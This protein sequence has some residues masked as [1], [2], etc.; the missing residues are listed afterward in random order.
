MAEL[1]ELPKGELVPLEAGKW[2]DVRRTENAVPDHQPDTLS[3]TLD[4]E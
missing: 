2:V 4:R 3:K 1:C